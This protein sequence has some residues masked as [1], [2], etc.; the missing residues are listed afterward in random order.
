MTNLK[1]SIWFWKENL[2]KLDHFIEKISELNNKRA[3]C[4]MFVTFYWYNLNHTKLTLW[5][6]YD[7]YKNDE[8]DKNDGNFVLLKIIW[9]RYISSSLEILLP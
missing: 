7:S 4:T 1:T 2:K 6:L 5:W 8:N 3:K 9:N